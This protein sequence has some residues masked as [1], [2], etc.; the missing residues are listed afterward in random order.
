MFEYLKYIGRI[1]IAFI[2]GCIVAI[3]PYLLGRLHGIVETKFNQ[4][5]KDSI[6][7]VAKRDSIDKCKKDSLKHIERLQGDSIAEAERLRQDSINEAMRY[8]NHIRINTFCNLNF[9]QSRNDVYN[10]MTR[11]GYVSDIDRE[12]IENRLSINF[13]KNPTIYFGGIQWNKVI[14]YFYK[15]KL[16]KIE[17]QGNESYD[18]I[19]QHLEN[20]Y[21]NI[22]EDSFQKFVIRTRNGVSITLRN[23]S[24][25]S[26]IYYNPIFENRDAIEM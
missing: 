25:I 24:T 12:Y 16:N 3:A 9:G 1:I 17:F 11:N 5:H 10:N 14:V 8:V 23:S 22:Y 19:K 18:A 7:L 4:E 2:C 21:R 6:A 15:D 26:L 13:T 20:K